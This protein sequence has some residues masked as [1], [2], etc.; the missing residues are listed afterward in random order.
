MR[1]ARKIIAASGADSE[2]HF[3]KVEAINLGSTFKQQS[4]WWLNHAETRKRRP[5]K[6]RTLVG[7]RTALNKWLLPE[8]G[9]VPLVQMDN[10]AMKQLVTKLSQSGLKPNTIRDYTNVVKLVV[11]SALNDRGEQVCPRK[12]NHDFCD[13][14][15]VKNVKRPSFEASEVASLL[16]QSTGWQHM[17]YALLAGSGLRIGEALALQVE[18]IQ[19]TMLS[20]ESTVW[21][22]ELSDPKMGRPRSVDLHSSLADLLRQFLGD[23]TTG[24]VF[25]SKRGRPLGENNVMNR[26]FNPLLKEL[27]I[28]RKGF[29]AFRRFRVHQLRHNHVDESLI[30]FWLGHAEKSMTDLY[31]R[32]ES[33]TEDRQREAERAGLGF[34][35]QNRDYGP[36]GP[37]VG[38]N[39]T[40]A[41]PVVY[42]EEC[43]A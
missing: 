22:Y 9:S 1:K 19:G 7:W 18:N 21:R 8:L 33:H 12:W 5:V 32:W 23:R 6:P 3:N 35:I 11:A 41:Q 25:Q 39:L 13:M 38:P 26:H 36:N 24:F 15:V 16:R 17:L 10:L 30:Q 20:I 28:A 14:P 37:K 29:H 34:E 27:G 40:N 4:E 31:E 43:V 42:G 2:E